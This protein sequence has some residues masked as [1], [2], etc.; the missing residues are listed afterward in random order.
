MTAVVAEMGAAVKGIDQFRISG[1]EYLQ[2][3]R[4]IFILGEHVD[5]DVAERILREVMIN[6]VI[7]I[8]HCK[9]PVR[10]QICR[11]SILYKM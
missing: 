8:E 4:S 5:V 10:E 1:R 9:A 2:T 7:E 6:K 3:V 11:R